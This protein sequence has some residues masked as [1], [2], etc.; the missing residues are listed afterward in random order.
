MVTNARAQFSAEEIKGF[1]TN[2]NRRSWSFQGYKIT[3]G[4]GCQGNSE[5]FI[6]SKDHTVTWKKCVGGQQA[7]K[8]L[9]W[10]VHIVNADNP[11]E[12]VL[13]LG[14]NI[15][16]VDEAMGSLKTARIDFD[17][18]VMKKKNKLMTWRVVAD[19]K[20]CGERQATLTSLD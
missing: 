16:L 1:L 11:D 4:A 13:E 7:V 12:W 5:E 15:Q 17:L 9:Q 19:C 18:P 10:N 14:E 2:N 8:T 6:F 20:T 3:M